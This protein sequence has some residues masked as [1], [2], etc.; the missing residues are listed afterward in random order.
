MSRS[1]ETSKSSFRSA[2]SAN[3]TAPSVVASSWRLVPVVVTMSPRRRCVISASPYGSA[4]T[5]RTLAP[6]AKAYTTPMRASTVS[7]PPRSRAARTMS[8]TKAKPSEPTIARR[9][10]PASPW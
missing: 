2:K 4:A 1:N 10:S 9:R 7:R 5:K 3:A 6:A 8:P